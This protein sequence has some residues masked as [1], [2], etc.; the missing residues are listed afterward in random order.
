M[1]DCKRD[2]SETI[3]QIFT[4]FAG[5]RGNLLGKNHLNLWDYLYHI[6]DARSNEYLMDKNMHGDIM[7]R[8]KLHE[9]IMEDVYEIVILRRMNK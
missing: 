2:Y 9:G 8:C 6:L 7:K 5:L 4:K 1:S 3:Q